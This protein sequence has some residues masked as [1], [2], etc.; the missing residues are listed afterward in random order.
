VLIIASPKKAFTPNPLRDDLIKSAIKE[1]NVDPL[2]T[3]HLRINK[4]SNSSKDTGKGKGSLSSPVLKA[5]WRKFIKC[6]MQGDGLTNNSAKITGPSEKSK[7][8][9]WAC[10][11]K[12]CTKRR[13]I[14]EKLKVDE[15]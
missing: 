7:G 6:R 15:R 2:P 3:A 9:A 10:S 5:K 13:L 12:H 11:V 4:H 14:I 8:S 1:I